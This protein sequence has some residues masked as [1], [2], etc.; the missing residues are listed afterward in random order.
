MHPILK[1]LLSGII[2]AIRFSLTTCFT[3]KTQKDDAKRLRAEA[4]KGDAD[5][6]YGLGVWHAQGWGVAKACDI[7]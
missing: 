1:R 2:L 4:E 3:T 6:Q 7:G 5:A